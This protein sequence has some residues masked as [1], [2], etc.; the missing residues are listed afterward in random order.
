MP[1]ITPGEWQIFMIT[2]PAGES[3][4]IYSQDGDESIDIAHIPMEW[5]N[6][7]NAQAMVSIPKLL[8][9]CRMFVEWQDGSFHP[10]PFGIKGFFE[11]AQE[12]LASIEEAEA[13]QDEIKVIEFK[14]FD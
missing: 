1:K 11:L 5:A 4:R 13:H 12:V 7:V 8:K 14:G 10:S 6:P 9:L 3:Y 2:S